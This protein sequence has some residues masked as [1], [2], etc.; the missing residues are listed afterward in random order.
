MNKTVI[1][2]ILLILCLCFTNCNTDTNP[3]NS[4]QT[5]FS[6]KVNVRDK[7]GNPVS[8]I[9]VAAW[10]FLKK[11][12]GQII[13]KKN[14]VNDSIM[15]STSIRIRIQ[16]NSNVLL[17]VYDLNDN[18]ISNIVDS[19]L[20]KGNYEFI[21]A[22]NDLKP[23]R[24]FK[25][26]IV[27][28]DSLFTQELFVDSIYMTLF[29]PDFKRCFLGYTNSEGIYETDDRL[30]FPSTI[31]NFIPLKY[32]G[33]NPFTNEFDTSG[34]FLFTDSIRIVLTDTLSGVQNIYTNTI[35]SQQNEYNFMW[36]ESGTIFKKSYTNQ[37][38]FTKP[39]DST[40][41]KWNLFQNYPNPFN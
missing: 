35:S 8:N 18:L 33:W 31:D 5:K 6:F 3:V 16:D 37:K 12:D 27:A 39:N 30:L 17:N 15:A 25:C 13:G 4:D 19:F 36:N 26:K 22:I 41:Y 2:S 7:N 14:I 24:F 38:Y 28:L 23:V 32:G 20:Q 11:P 21:W 29:Q 10:N 1:N 40:N 34:T 9:R